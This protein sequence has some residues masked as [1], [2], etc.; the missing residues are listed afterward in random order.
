LIRLSTGEREVE[1]LTQDDLMTGGAEGRPAVDVVDADEHL[2][3]AARAGW[4][5]D[6]ELELVIAR[7]V[8]AGRPEELAIAIEAGPRRQRR[9]RRI[10]QRVAVDI[11]GRERELK[12][13]IFAPRLRGD[14][15]CYG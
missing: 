7:L 2:I 11:G 15:H 9:E 10:G 6:C 12:C 3:L 1:R 8:I 14:R 13:R 4:I 5:T